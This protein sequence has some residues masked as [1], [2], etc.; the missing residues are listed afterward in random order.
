V[1]VELGTNNWGSDETQFKKEITDFYTSAK[2]LNPSAKYYWV[3]YVGNGKYQVPLANHTKTL[4]D[5]A[6]ANNITIIDWASIGAPLI[7]PNDVHPGG[8]YSQLTDLVKQSLSGSTGCSSTT[9]TGWV[10]PIKKEDLKNWS[11][12]KNNEASGSGLN[13]CWL[14]QHITSGVIGYHAALDIGVVNKPVYAANDGKIVRK[15]SDGYNTLVIQADGSPTYYAVY[16]HMSTISVSVGDTVKA[17]Q[18]IGVSGDVG[19]PGAPHLHFGISTTNDRFGTYADPWATVN[20]LDF[21]PNDYS[22]AL[23]K[24]DNTGSCLTKDIMGR[25]D[26]GF[27]IYKTKGVDPRYK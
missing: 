4:L 3:N 11:T 14:H 20:P 17:G 13:Q 2:V 23:L 1:V 21:L 5:L 24:D 26:F 7:G 10:W 19:A 22:P 18:Q 15:A 25:P 12:L 6:T 27:N 8:H 9:A 16:E